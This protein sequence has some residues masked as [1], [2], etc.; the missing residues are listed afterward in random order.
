MARLINNVKEKS[1]IK[2]ETQV[3][4]SKIHHPLIKKRETS[5]IFARNSFG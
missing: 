4:I 5:R 2:K 3:K 1:L